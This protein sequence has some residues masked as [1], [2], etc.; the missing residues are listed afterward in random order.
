MPAK[1][2]L[3]FLIL[4]QVSFAFATPLSGRLGEVFKTGTSAQISYEQTATILS[5]FG[6]NADYVNAIESQLNSESRTPLEKQILKNS[7][8]RFRLFDLSREMTSFLLARWQERTDLVEREHEMHE[9]IANL[10]K[11]K[12][13]AL[14]RLSAE[15][16]MDVDQ[17]LT[18]KINELVDL[19]TKGQILDILLTTF[20]KSN[21]EKFLANRQKKSEIDLVS[22]LM[23][24][25]NQIRYDYL[26]ISQTPYLGKALLI[27]VID[28]YQKNKM[29]SSLSALNKKLEDDPKIGQD[30]FSYLLAKVNGETLKPMDI[31]ATWSDRL[32]SYYQSKKWV[33]PTLKS[34]IGDRGAL[35]EGDF[36]QFASVICLPSPEECLD[37]SKGSLKIHWLVEAP[38]LPAGGLRIVDVNGF[39]PQG[40]VPKLSYVRWDTKQGN[41]SLRNGSSNRQARIGDF[42]AGGLVESTQLNPMYSSLGVTLALSALDPSKLANTNPKIVVDKSRYQVSP[43][44]LESSLTSELWMPIVAQSFLSFIKAPQFSLKE[45]SLDLIKTMPLVGASISNLEAQQRDRSPN[46]IRSKIQCTPSKTV[47]KTVPE[48]IKEFLYQLGFGDKYQG[49]WLPYSEIMA[50]YNQKKITYNEMTRKQQLRNVNDYTKVQ[51]SVELATLIAMSLAHCEVND[52]FVRRSSALAATLASFEAPAAI[53]ENPL[54]FKATEAAHDGD[55]QLRIRYEKSLRAKMGSESTKLVKV[56]LDSLYGAEVSKLAE[57][58][59]FASQV[60]RIQSLSQQIIELAFMN[61]QIGRTRFLGRALIALL[62]RQAKLHG[63]YN[64][65]REGLTK[66]L[67]S[68]QLTFENFI[69]DQWK[70]RSVDKKGNRSD[71]LV[72]IYDMGY[73]FTRGINMESP[74]IPSGSIPGG[75]QRADAS[76]PSP[77]YYG[78]KMGLVGSFAAAAFVPSAESTFD[79]VESWKDKKFYTT[80]NDGY[81]HVGYTLVRE[82][83]GIKMSWIL[84]NYP[85]PIADMEVDLTGVPYNP[86]GIRISGLEQ[87]YRVDHHSRLAVSNMVNS[88]PPEDM[89]VSDADYFKFFEYAKRQVLAFVKN[90]KSFEYGGKAL[91]FADFPNFKVFSPILEPTTG[92]PLRDVETTEQF[93]EDPWMV[94]ITPHEFEEMHK[95]VFAAVLENHN[96]SRDEVKKWFDHVRKAALDKIFDLM[97]KGVTFV[98]ITPYGQY[99]KGGA[100]CSLTGVLGWKLGTGLDIQETKDTWH[101]IV[102][103]VKKQEDFL[104][105]QV[106]SDPDI[107][108]QIKNIAMMHDMPI[109]APSGLAAQVYNRIQDVRSFVPP[110]QELVDRFRRQFGREIQVN[111]DPAVE[112]MVLKLQPEVERY[113]ATTPLDFTEVEAIYN[114]TLEIA[115]SAKGC[116]QR[117]SVCGRRLGK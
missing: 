95:I 111:V 60:K 70:I 78:K 90:K 80:F 110:Y 81:S 103:A 22:E 89:G 29:A 46:L 92:K 41:A 66:I 42:I 16:G 86:G 12:L 99:Y 96:P 69:G 64:L 48:D 27:A 18:Q 72:S 108:E 63:Q 79:A 61:H 73:V 84:D 114:D 49:Q 19:E 33:L 102:N 67:E 100:Y 43:I 68:N 88:L 2:I 32:S 107:S 40:Y 83:Q 113:F 56:I 91:N 115:I 14:P 54:A 53:I 4:V 74:T 71:E 117:N 59:K 3:V 35:K 58:L 21:S 47:V 31:V 8:Q 6:F 13:V 34:L 36:N 97:Y 37:S 25:Y 44:V 112:S 5:R 101:R 87:F 98:W 51:A 30:G 20:G 10:L 85:T 55:P 50:I 104:L 57:D 15:A 82:S 76:N 52:S 65:A 106:S 9:L 38:I 1:T 116:T 23:A 109:V 77:Y 17:A 93:V 45:T 26:E 24:Q 94:E 7:K 75:D 28:Y 62:M 39:A 105:K 11:M